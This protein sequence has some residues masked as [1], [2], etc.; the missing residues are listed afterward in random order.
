MQVSDEPHPLLTPE[1]LQLKAPQ[2]GN[3]QNKP[4]PPTT[5][6]ETQVSSS[7]ASSSASP[8]EQTGQDM[9]ED[10]RLVDAFGTLSIGP[11][12]ES[13]FLG[14]TARSE[15]L[16]RALLKPPTHEELECPRIPK[17]L[18]DMT[19]T[20][21]DKDA[22]EFGGEI[23]SMLPSLSEAIRLC[24][25]YL[26]Y[27]K[28]FFTP[29]PRSELFDEILAVVYRAGSFSDINCYGSVGLLFSAFSLA[30]LFDPSR[31]PYNIEAQEF[32]YVAR[33]TVGINPPTKRTTLRIIQTTLH[34]AQYLELSDWQATGTNSALPVAGHAVRLAI[35][36]GL[37][38]NSS[39]WKLPEEAQQRRNRAFWSVFSND[40]W[41][42]FAYG[43]PPN[44]SPA[45]VDCPLPSDIEPFINP[46]G[47]RETGFHLWVWQYSAFMHTVME[48]AF[49]CT[50]PAYA[51]ILELDRKIRDFPVPDYL[52][53]CCGHEIRPEMYMK[54]YMVLSYKETTLLHLHRAYLAQALLEQPH[55]LTHHR[56][57][58]SVMST[59]RS[60]WRLIQGLKQIWDQVP[61]LVS[62]YNLAWSQALSAA[63]VMC[64]LITRSPQ[65]KM[66]KSSLAELDDV[67]KLFEDAAPTCRSA[68]N[69]LDTVLTLQ[70]KAHEAVDQ[71]PP[72]PL[73]PNSVSSIADTLTPAELDRLGGRTQLV[74]PEDTDRRRRRQSS[75]SGN[76]SPTTLN[77]NTHIP[78]SN[79]NSNSTAD[80][81]N[82]LLADQGFQ[83][84][85]PTI[86]QD[87]RTLDSI[88]GPLMR[89]YEGEINFD[90]LMDG[91]GGGIGVGAD[92]EQQLRLFG[93]GSMSPGMFSATG[94]A[95][96][97]G[98]GMGMG[99]GM[100][101][102]MGDSDEG[103]DYEIVAEGIASTVSKTLASVDEGPPQLVAV[104]TSTT[105]KKFAK[106]PHDIFK[107]ARILKGLNHENI[108]TILDV[109]ND[110]NESALSIWMP[111]IPFS[112]SQLL[113]SPSLSSPSSSSSSSSHEQTRFQ[114]ICTSIT[115]QLFSALTYLHE[116]QKIAHRDIKPTNVL[117][118][119]EGCVQLIDFGITWREDETE[120]D[121]K[122]D[123]WPEFRGEG[124]G[125]GMYFEV[126]TGPY[127]AP[128][129]LFGTRSYNAFA[130]D[131]WSLGCV[132]AEFFTP[133]A[134]SSSNSNSD[135]DSF[136]SSSSSNS[137]YRTPLFDGTRG[138]IGLAWSI[139]KILGTPNETSWP[140]FKDLP[141]AERVE[142]AVAEKQDLVGVLPG[143]GLGLG[144]GDGDGEGEGDEK[145]DEK[146]WREGILDI[147]QRLLVYPPEQRLDAR[148][149]LEHGWFRGGG[150]GGG[151]V[152][153]LTPHDSSNSRWQDRSLGNLL[154]EVL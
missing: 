144:L 21:S 116:S 109:F 108:I 117:L 13:T 72:A 70:R 10:E 47:G 35:S 68:S 106:E 88:G 49:G 128:E 107:E 123:L 23:L 46:E 1:L 63:I 24:E 61:Q 73:N 82:G 71:T 113:D 137:H 52:R 42:S 18:V 39:R 15:F 33:A 12:G 132:L 27:G 48:A 99:A 115:H 74:S 62:R 36:V 59:Y 141:D 76:G 2:Q 139:F 34:L 20:D 9:D 135:D 8:P 75:S 145:G 65:S 6:S 60:A 32:Y 37:H 119:K 127:R 38:L 93:S 81:L 22:D 100:G 58:P 146:R 103:S 133:L 5:V 7:G 151:G 134:P 136:F 110:T 130:I 31:T 97:Q 44:I 152:P 84:M 28:Y 125:K 69:I 140:G 98:M 41:M 25:V 92:Q 149:A 50:T 150:G 51:K 102:G 114:I 148:S 85:H 30:S 104:K 126:S 87:M 118:T 79:S 77:G 142:F 153:R 138:E 131:R 96:P 26:E 67:A 120:E 129:L 101:A 54:R 147:I 80:I 112:L 86:A 122:G 90:S 89:L 11:N 43:R 121:K 95:Y 16:I 56:L 83:N 29:V 4:S 3:G 14:K 45:Y 154:V 143:L 19:C 78:N 64:I 17:R 111:F 66:T 55:D 57:V 40:T 91:V 53:V 124:K 105:V 94:P